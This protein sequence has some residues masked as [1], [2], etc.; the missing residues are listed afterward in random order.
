A[1]GRAMAIE[2]AAEA[3]PEITRV[4]VMAPRLSGELPSDTA[5]QLRTIVADNLAEDGLEVVSQGEAT[6]E[7][8]G[9]VSQAASTAGAGY[10]V[11]TE[12]IG[13]EDEFTVTVTLYAGG[14]GEA[15][16]PFEDGCS[17][18]G[19]VEVRDMVR[20][21][22]LDA[23]AEVVRR[24]AVEAAAVVV[25]SV[26]PVAGPAES[27]RPRSKL[28]P[29]G[30]ALIG[31]GSAATLGG[32]V[33]LALHQRSAGCLDNPRGGECVPVRFTTAAPGGAVLGGGVLTAA[34][35]V[36]MVVLGRRADARG[37]Q[38][39]LGVAAGGLSLRF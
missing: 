35:G 33:L 16:A 4:L 24:R 30:W 36:L 9:C 31:A 27:T 2:P 17:I 5:V 19:F 23:R 6:C 3:E 37:R 13:D 32:V 29:S 7:D 11:G 38:A 18:C 22:A 12:V 15:L 34:A 1:P 8:P 25:E 21:R 20:L 28:G 26:E 39:R 10:V 14:T